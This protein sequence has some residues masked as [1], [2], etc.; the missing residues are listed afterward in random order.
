MRLFLGTYSM[1]AMTAANDTVY[2]F[3]SAVGQFVLTAS[4]RSQV[5]PANKASY[6]NL[7][8]ERLV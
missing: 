7:S 8:P 5:N 6:Q 2:S 4:F 1:Y 3:A